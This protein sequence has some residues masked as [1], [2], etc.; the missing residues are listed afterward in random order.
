MPTWCIS[1]ANE[2]QLAQ[3]KKRLPK[4]QSIM[5]QNYLGK[6]CPSSLLRDDGTGNREIPCLFYDHCQPSNWTDDVKTILNN[7]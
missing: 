5:D 2:W 4:A 3:L 6:Y 7:K 1:R